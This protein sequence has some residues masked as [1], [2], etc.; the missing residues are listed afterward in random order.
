[1]THRINTGVGGKSDSDATTRLKTGIGEFHF[2]INSE[3]GRMIA[4]TC[5][6][7][8]DHESLGPVRHPYRRNKLEKEPLGTHDDYSKSM[9]NSEDYTRARIALEQQ[10]KW[11]RLQTFFKNARKETPFGKSPTARERI[12]NDLPDPEK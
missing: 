4:C 2:S 12:E 6:Q 1:M 9:S 3:T 8:R 11:L 10:V 5:S 7:K